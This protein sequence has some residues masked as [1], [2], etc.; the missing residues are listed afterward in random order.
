M[1][2]WGTLL[3]SGLRVTGFGYG[4]GAGFARVNLSS[5]RNFNSN[6]IM[7]ID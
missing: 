2:C 1:V 7:K 4:N 3:A 6:C 5:F